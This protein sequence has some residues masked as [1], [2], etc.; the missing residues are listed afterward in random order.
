MVDILWVLYL[1]PEEV[2]VALYL[3]NSLGSGSLASHSRLRRTRTT[4]VHNSAVY[5]GGG[6]YPIAGIGPGIYVAVH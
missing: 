4:S 5:G 2:S 3:F 1:T 6:D